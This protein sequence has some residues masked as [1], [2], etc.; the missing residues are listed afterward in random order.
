MSFDNP[1]SHGGAFPHT[2]CYSRKRPRRGGWGKSDDAATLSKSSH[3]PMILLSGESEHRSING[4][5]PNPPR[6]FTSW[7]QYPEATGRTPRTKTP[8]THCPARALTVL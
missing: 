1:E 4:L 3:N 8:S 6:C 2:Q 7:K 5:P